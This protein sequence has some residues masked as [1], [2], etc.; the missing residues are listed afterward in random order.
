MEAT[1]DIVSRPPLAK[2]ITPDENA[3]LP[4][5]QS[6][7]AGVDNLTHTGPKD[8][9]GSDKLYKLAQ[10]LGVMDVMRWKPRKVRATLP[11]LPLPSSHVFRVDDGTGAV[12]CSH[13]GQQRL[14]GHHRRRGAAARVRRGVQDREG[15]VPGQARQD[16]TARLG[17]IGEL[18]VYECFLP[19]LVPIRRLFSVYMS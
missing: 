11:V 2:R 15:A 14:A 5:N 8:L 17:R 9:T 7:L 4:S 1:K 12:G 3:K 13:C 6:R 10:K 18:V 19:R 16:V